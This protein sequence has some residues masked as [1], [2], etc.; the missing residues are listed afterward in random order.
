[1]NLRTRPVRIVCGSSLLVMLALV[2]TVPFNMG[3]CSA[4]GIDVGGMVNAGN[5]FRQ[6]AGLNE[7]QERAIGESVSLAA[8]N[9]YGVISDEQLA[10]YVVL[11]GQTVASRTNRAD[12][13]WVF[14]VLNT[15]KIN[16]FSGPGG[17]VWVTRGA[18][19]MMQDESELAGVLG[20]EIGHVVKHHGLDAAKN[21]GMLDA[22]ATAAAS[23]SKQAAAFGDLSDKVVD[24]IMNEGFSQ[25]QEFEADAE[26]V[27]FVVAAGYDPNGFLHFLQRVRDHQ[28]SGQPAFSTHPGVNE[29]I[30][31]V[32][33][34][35]SASGAGGKGATLKDRF[36]F[37]TGRTAQPASFEI[38]AER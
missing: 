17:Y 11:V 29:R 20:H 4:G 1:M 7:H 12:Q 21:A 34:E 22:F 32:A 16:A 18:I 37:Y 3:G 30:K 28:T 6:A 26:S 8:T 14:G 10:Q 27:K 5:K 19:A 15:D 2:A 36:N 38:N 35:I 13:P 25:P 31:R 24:I 33:D 9:Q 23:S